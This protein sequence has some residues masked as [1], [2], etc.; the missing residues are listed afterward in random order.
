[1][2]L[3][4][5]IKESEAALKSLSEAVLQHPEDD[6]LRQSCRMAEESHRKLCAWR[7]KQARDDYMRRYALGLF[8]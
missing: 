4:E 3:D 2:T 5:Q 7:T 8:R 6:A 1:M